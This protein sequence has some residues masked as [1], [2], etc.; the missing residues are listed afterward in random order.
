MTS[1]AVLV[2][3]GELPLSSQR[4][5]NQ[6][7]FEHLCG[8]RSLFADGLYVDPVRVSWP[9]LPSVGGMRGVLRPVKE[10]ERGAF[11]VASPTFP[12]PFSWRRPIAR[13]QV[14]FLA[15]RLRAHLRGRPYCLWV[16]NPEF[17]PFLLAEALRPGASSMVVDLSDDFTAFS[18]R[19]PLGLERRVRKLVADSDALITV[20][21]HVARKFPHAKSLVFPNAT[22][23]EALQR[24]DPRYSL[25]DVLPKA[26]NRK[27]VGFIGGLHTGRVDEPLLMEL[28]SRLKAR[29][30]P[31]SR[32]LERPFAAGEARFATQREDL[33]S[34]P[35]RRTGLR[36]P[37][38]RCRDRSPSRQRLHPGKRPAQGPGLP[39][40]RGPGRQY[41]VFRS[42]EV[43]QRT[44]CGRQ[45]RRVRV[46]SGDAA[47][48]GDDTRPRSRH[49]RRTNRVLV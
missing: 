34:R 10:A 26:D 16:N 49:R 2:N 15:G 14:S 21:E 4:R 43:R 1:P 35:L 37:C 9:S 5:R 41:A 17:H 45:H 47:Q 11:S 28:V 42:R 44:L 31:L 24:C 12:L 48:R 27:I 25:G 13:A 3:L 18:D 22:D 6:V 36:D 30:L 46:C 33:R 32:L 39:G 38:L 20:N 19:D 23:F 40:L 29:R 8:E 7:I